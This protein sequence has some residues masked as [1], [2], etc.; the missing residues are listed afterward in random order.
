MLYHL[1]TGAPPPGG[2]ETAL[3]VPDGAAVPKPLAGVVS[4]ATRPDPA[5]RYPSAGELSADIA[6]FRE[7]SPVSAYRETL[8]D[9]VGRLAYRYRTPLLLVLAYLVMRVL[10]LAF[11]K[12][13]S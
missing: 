10:L 6:R 2:G 13:A 1:L 9:R 8:I 7:G 12:P 4:R 3:M 5:D 11:F